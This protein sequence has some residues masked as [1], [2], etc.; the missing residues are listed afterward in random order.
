M[1]P[2]ECGWKGGPDSKIWMGKNIRVASSFVPGQLWGPLEFHL[3]SYSYYLPSSSG[4]QQ[5][6]STSLCPEECCFAVPMR[7]LPGNERHRG[8]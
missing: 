8:V 4:K 1:G 2:E 7:N 5:P 6:V 3:C